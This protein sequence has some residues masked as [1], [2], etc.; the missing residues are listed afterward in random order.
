MNHNE[1]SGIIIQKATTIHQSLGPGLL[2]SV[3]KNI[4]IHELLACG[5]H[6]EPEV[7][8]PVNY[9]GKVF[10]FGFRADIIVENKIIIEVKSVENVQ[11]MHMKQLLTYLKLTKLRL[12][13]LLNFNTVLLKDGIIRIVNGL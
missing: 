4:L 9:G 2:E 13:L 8:I 7:M 6:A 10:E 1:I 11:A 5:L 3:Y 12:G